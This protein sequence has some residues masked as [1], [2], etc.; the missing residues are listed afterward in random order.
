[1]AIIVLSIVPHSADVERLFST[2]NGIQS[3]KRNHL[4]VDT[5]EKIAKVRNNLSYE[6][7]LREQREGKATHRKHT[8]MHTRDAPGI[9]VELVED[10]QDPL[11]WKP[12]LQPPDGR[13]SAPET[14]QSTE[15]AVADTFRALR[16][17]IEAEH[18]DQPVEAAKSAAD[19]TPPSVLRGEVFDFAEVAAVDEGRA[20][21][22]LDEEIRVIGSGQAAD[23]SIA[24][25]M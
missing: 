22:A 14:E 25:F 23:W 12:P 17:E 9:D 2:L 10:L 19:S 16:A 15:E 4:A 18:R 24:D 1:M 7:K 11:S 8:H 13:E 3:V 6:L 20:P 5:F 21:R